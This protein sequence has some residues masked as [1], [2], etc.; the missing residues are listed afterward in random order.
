MTSRTKIIAC[1]AAVFGFVYPSARSEQT[2][3]APPGFVSLTSAL[4]LAGANNLDVKIVEEHL[5]EARAD[6]LIAI[7]QFLPSVRGGLGFRQHDGNAQ[8]TEGRIIDVNKQLY[9]GGAAL[10]AQIKL[11]D[12]IY[13]T[14]ASHQ[15]VKAAGFATEARR[16]DSIYQAAISFYDLVLSHATV[17]VSEESVKIA[18]EYALQVGKAAEAGLAYRGDA[19]RAIAQVQKNQLALEQACVQRRIAAARLSQILNLDPAIELIPDQTTLAPIHLLS[20]KETLDSLV[21]KAT[22][23]RPEIQ[24]LAARLRAARS[25]HDGSVFGPTVPAITAEAFWGGLGG[26]DGNAGPANF[27]NSSD[28]IVAAT[29]TLGPG[30][31]FDIGQINK[32]KAQVKLGELE[33]EKFR[34]E[35]IIQV[36]AGHARINSMSNQLNS[37]QQAMS[38]IEKNLALAR[39]RKTFGIGEILE[40]IDAQEQRTKTRMDYLGVLAE[41]NKAQFA[42]IRALGLVPDPKPPSKTSGTVR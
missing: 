27:D 5:A 7:E 1:C 30:G 14:L 24:Q 28:Y 4:R 3:N 42:M 11:G 26:G 12:A 8:T 35:I 34:Q 2:E 13:E 10:A 25:K 40:N 41:Y 18:Q 31:L 21:A 37:A 9:T 16:L 22:S 39:E 23:N 33:A 29:W 19:L 6:H 17:D 15:L 32:T 38:S 36:V 20:E